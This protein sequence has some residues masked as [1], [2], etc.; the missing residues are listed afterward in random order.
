MCIRDR[1]WPSGRP[2]RRAGR[3]PRPLQPEPGGRNGAWGRARG[4]QRR[5]RRPRLVTLR[6]RGHAQAGGQPRHPPH[7]QR[8]PHARPPPAG[9]YQRLRS[10]ARHR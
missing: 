8:R 1:R 10:Q 6:R 9:Q 2:P 3:H 5:C 7:C 4:S